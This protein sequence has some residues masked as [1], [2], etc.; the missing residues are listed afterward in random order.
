MLVSRN[1]FHAVSALQFIL[2]LHLFILADQIL[3]D[4]TLAAFIV[5]G[6][7]QFV[8]LNLSP[9]FGHMIDVSGFPDMAANN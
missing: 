6:P 5:C 8:T 2:F 9:R 4:P 7:L 3:V 1:V